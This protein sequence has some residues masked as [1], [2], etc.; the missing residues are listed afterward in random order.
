M[1]LAVFEFSALTQTPVAVEFFT[2]NHLFSFQH[3]LKSVPISFSIPSV[4]LR[5]QQRSNTVQIPQTPLIFRIS[6]TKALIIETFET[7]KTSLCDPERRLYI[8]LFKRR[9]RV[10]MS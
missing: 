5:V 6:L 3:R 9:A 8:I 4:A 7:N 1:F 10:N 2:I